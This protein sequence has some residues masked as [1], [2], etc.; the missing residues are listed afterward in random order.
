MT[1]NEKIE[2]EVDGSKPKKR[3]V[4]SKQDRWLYF[5]LVAIEKAE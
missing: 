4:I 2:A 3:R 1:S 5:K